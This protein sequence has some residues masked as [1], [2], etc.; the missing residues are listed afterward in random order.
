[1]SVHVAVA[2]VGFRNPEDVVQCVHA[3]AR[4]THPDFEVTVCENG[5]PAAYEALITRLPSRLPGGQAVRV[6]LA[7]GN[8]GY[9]GGVNLCIRETRA[10][11]A[12]WV[13]NPDT[14]P[15]ADAMALMAA[16]LERG[17][18]DAVGC[19][20][21]TP[22][23]RLQSVGGFWRMPF[24][25]AVS[26]GYGAPLADL[27]QAT[28]GV[29]ARQNYLNGASM[30]VGRRFVE[31]AGLMREDYFL[32]C[33]EVEWCLRA[34]DRGLKLGLE[35]RALVLH[36]QGTTTG[37]PPEVRQKGRL[38]VHLNERNRLLLTRDCCPRLLP[39]AALAAF[40]LIWLRFARRGAW[41]QVGYAIEG[42]WDGLLDRRGVPT[43][44]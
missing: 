3:L 25:R 21:H 30:M 18:C 23:G 41:K 16:R 36:H 38:A 29:E 11:D 26:I 6:V 14:E 13:L 17:D 24:A 33:E 34:I 37:N 8:L 5:G 7:P 28:A 19:V 39:L 9:A 42:W 10:A 35:P 32:Y 20:I 31:Q 4:A 2:I 1:L 27:A 44:A 12:W 15:S 22:A 40:G 43:W